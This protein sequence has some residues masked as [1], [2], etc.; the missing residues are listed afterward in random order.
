MDSL[1]EI[2]TPRM[3][4]DYL[5]IGYSKALDL[6]KSGELTCLKIGNSYKVPKTAFSTWLNTPGLRKVL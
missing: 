3:I 1:P 4:A 6:V 5:D 2:L